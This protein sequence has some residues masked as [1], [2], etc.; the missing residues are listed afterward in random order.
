MIPEPLCRYSAG[1]ILGFDEG[2]GGRT[3]NVETWCI[4]MGPV[5]VIYMDKTLFKNL[6]KHHEKSINKIT[7]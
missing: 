4:C 3:S 1:D 5:E 7:W 2:D 6:W